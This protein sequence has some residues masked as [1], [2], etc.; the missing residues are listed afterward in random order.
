MVH[1]GHHRG[2]I[3]WLARALGHPVST[4]TMSGMWQWAARARE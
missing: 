2:Q 4:E 1:D 3:L